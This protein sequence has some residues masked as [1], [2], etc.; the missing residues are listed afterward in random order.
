MEYRTAPTELLCHEVTS[1]LTL[2][3]ASAVGSLLAVLEKVAGGKP[4]VRIRFDRLHSVI[5]NSPR[6]NPCECPLPRHLGQQAL[7]YRLMMMDAMTLVYELLRRCGFSDNQQ[8]SLVCP[9]GV[10]SL[11]TACSASSMLPWLQSATRELMSVLN[12]LRGLSQYRMQGCPGDPPLYSQSLQQS[13]VPPPAEPAQ[14]STSQTCTATMQQCS[15]QHSPFPSVPSHQLS[16]VP[17]MPA[18][19]NTTLPFDVVLHKGELRPEYER[20]RPP[21]RIAQFSL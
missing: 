2:H 13:H 21:G 15:Q 1:R 16:P 6:S 9:Q 11:H 3:P 17:S 19:A 5:E 10:Y 12:Y 4:L 8:G 18:N 14:L 7:D 20:P